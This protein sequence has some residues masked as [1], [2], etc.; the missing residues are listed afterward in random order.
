MPDQSLTTYLISFA[1]I[2]IVIAL[3]W[4]R[5]SRAQPLKLERLWLVPAGYLVV[6][7]GAF[8]AHPPS[9]IGWLFATAAL[10]L[11]GALGWQRG[12]LM[13]IEI[14]PETHALNQRGSPAAMLLIVA[15]VV[16][17]TGGRELATRSGF[18]LDPLAVTD[19]LIALALGLFS[20]TRLEMYLRARRMLAAHSGGDVG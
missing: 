18:H 13:T 14:D 16:A 2:A 11:G 4:R 15:L 17:R 8:Y 1:V 9:P 5:M 10:A 6:A 19:V 3:R 20:A 12:K 7:I